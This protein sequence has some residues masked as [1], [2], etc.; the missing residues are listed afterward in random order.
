MMPTLGLYGIQDRQDHARPLET[1]DH[2]LCLTASGEVVWAL[3]L[4]RHTRRKH[5]N[6]LPRHLEALLRPGDASLPREFRVALVDSF[7]GRA[8]VSTG[9]LWRF[10][11]NGRWRLTSRPQRGLGHVH[12]RD[13]ETW[14]VPH[15]L[16]HLG[17]CLPF[18]GNFEEGALCVHIDG[19]ASRSSVSVWL[20]RER[21]FQKLHSS[22]Q[23]F[24]AVTR[25]ANNNLVQAMTGHAWFD[26]QAVPGKLMALA[27]Y[28]RAEPEVLAWLR[29]NDWFRDIRERLDIPTQAARE[30][31]G[32]TG[33]WAWGDPLVR[34][35]AAC[36]QAEFTGQ[37]LRLLEHWQRR[38]GARSLYLSGGAA[39]N[40]V[41]NDL[42]ATS[43]LFAS[44][45]VPPCA[46]DSGLALGAAALVDFLD[47]A[48]I[49]PQGPFLQRF[50][51]DVALARSDESAGRAAALLAA[52]HVLAVCQGAGESGPRALGH[53]SLLALPTEA[54]RARVSETMKGREPYRPVAPMAL[55][56]EADRLF[57][58]RP[59]G[60]ELARFMLRSFPATE[61]CRRRAPG[62]VHVDGTARV[63]V[64]PEQEPEFAWL[65]S[66]LERLRAEYAVP[67]LLNTS[68]NGRGEPLVHTR[69]D[70]LNA[71]KRLEVDTLVLGDE[72]VS[73]GEVAA[74]RRSVQGAG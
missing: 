2:G 5:D 66:V 37:V 21:R 54:L 51:C 35:I 17:A 58:G 14:M 55:P 22:W 31:F 40:I 30:A 42:L 49:Q 52:G 60:S 38:T 16:A 33:E 15:E 65:R 34:A 20:H 18:Y 43:G 25:F 62:V 32:W 28:G 63:Q 72:L 27:S 23:L 57:E 74:P 59:S 3:E 36:V 6:H 13:V 24:E 48:D 4:E 7:V 1:H 41:L 45:R 8:F 9:G 29:R 44:V 67:C 46:S 70:A 47:G 68:F 11:P 64:V 50:G 53:R 26:H 69:G 12:H 19:G 61:E 10:E 39:L 71:A 56:S 73:F